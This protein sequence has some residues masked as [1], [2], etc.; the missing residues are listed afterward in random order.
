M[1]MFPSETK[2][3]TRKSPKKCIILLEIQGPHIRKCMIVSLKSLSH[4][5]PEIQGI[6]EILSDP[7]TYVMCMK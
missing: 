1:S 3:S 2:Y 6:H 5:K 4:D 7:E